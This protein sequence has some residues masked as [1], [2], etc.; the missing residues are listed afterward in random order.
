MHISQRQFGLARIL[1]L[2]GPLVG[3]AAAERLDQAI[4]PLIR[5]PSLLIVNV[6][7]VT[8]LDD[9]V[10]CVLGAAARDFRRNGGAL[11]VAVS[12]GAPQG[13]VP[14]R[15]RVFFDC[16]DSVEDA[17][18]DLRASM[19]GPVHRRALSRARAACHSWWRRIS[20]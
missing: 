10:L 13:L 11:R 19:S 3:L 2:R 20:R 14:R 18:A 5:E 16:F 9:E 6:A 7:Q 12:G 15:L 8:E 1:D 4:A 17:L